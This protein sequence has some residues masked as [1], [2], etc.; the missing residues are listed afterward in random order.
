MADSITL[1]TASPVR[2]AVFPEVSPQFEPNLIAISGGA[3][4]IMLRIQ[5]SSPRRQLQGI[6]T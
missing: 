4:S 1:K 3:K 2:C 6:S 5:G